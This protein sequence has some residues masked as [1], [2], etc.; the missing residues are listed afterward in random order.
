MTE[1]Y[2]IFANIHE[3]QVPKILIKLPVKMYQ[4]FFYQ[5]TCITLN[6]YTQKEDFSDHN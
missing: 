6:N 4:Y 1:S 5:Q 3:I 2:S